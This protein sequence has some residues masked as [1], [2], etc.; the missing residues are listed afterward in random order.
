MK[1]NLLIE[2]LD[3]SQ[4]NHKLLVKRLN[5]KK[6]KSLSGKWVAVANRKIISGESSAKV[7]KKAKIEEPIKEKILL[8]KIPTSKI[9]SIRF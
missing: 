2:I 6:G 5:S 9:H 8:T 3:V 1:S 7:M 4:V